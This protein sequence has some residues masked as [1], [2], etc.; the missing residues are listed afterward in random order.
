MKQE[1]LDAYESQKFISKSISV[2]QSQLV[3]KSS[4]ISI[5]APLV[6][7]IVSE[8][9]IHKTEIGGVK[10]IRHQSELSNGFDELVDVAKKNKIKTDGFLVQE[11]IE[12]QQLI[13][14]LKKDETFRHV[15]V[16]GMG[17]IFAEL[18]K[19]ISIRKCPITKEDAQSMIDGLKSKELFHGFRNIKLNTEILKENLIA[20]SN[21]PQK[22]KNIKELDINPYILNSRDGK[23]VDVRIVLEK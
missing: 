6:L 23:A 5:K 18:F 10:I 21:L 2:P 3:R 13:I 12:G 8:Q 19:D 7:K 16:L 4:E 22:H 11:F 17:G 14:G 1:V 20:I 9:A 15:I